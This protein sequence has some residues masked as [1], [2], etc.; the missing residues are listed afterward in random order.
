[1]RKIFAALIVL[2]LVGCAG[3]PAPNYTP[4][5][6]E[7]SF[8]EIGKESTVSLGEDMLRQGVYTETD[9][10]ETFEENN[11]KG[12]RISAGFYP[13]IVVEKDYTFHSF[14]NQKSMEGNG[15]IISAQDFLG[16]PLPVPG[17]IR[18][19]KVKQETC[20]I[21]GGISGPSCDTEHRFSRVRKPVLSE[22]D[23]QQTLIYSGRVGSKIRIGYRENSGGYARTAFS[24]EAEYDLNSSNEIAYRGARIRVIEA[25]NLKIKYVVLANF[26]S[27]RR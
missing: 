9:G 4:T 12:Y 10:V 16:F 7:I 3:T 15:Y 2:G 1:M 5:S 14:G 19:S 17:S 27:A 18:F 25:D 8:P 26:N 24:N 22:R 20:V 6:M 13:Q 23:F 11:I 21:I